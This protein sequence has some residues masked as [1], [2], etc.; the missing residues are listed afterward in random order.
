MPTKS[1]NKSNIKINFF[2]KKTFLVFDLRSFLRIFI[3]KL[4]TQI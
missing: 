2:Q 4:D 1:S 3:T